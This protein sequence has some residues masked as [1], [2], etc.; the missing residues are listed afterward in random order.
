[1]KFIYFLGMLTA[2]AQTSF[3]QAATPP[4]TG[5][6]FGLMEGIVVACSKIKPQDAPKYKQHLKSFAAVG[7]QSDNVAA[8]ARKT[9][10]YET[11]Y[12]AVIENFNNK[13]KEKAI[14]ACDE[15][16]KTSNQG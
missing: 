14:E 13:P 8:E 15:F 1:M 11:S 4:S 12:K 16:L 6:A 2:F 9:Q 3:V 5:E 7:A 10:A